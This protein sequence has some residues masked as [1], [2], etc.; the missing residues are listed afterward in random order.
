MK[1][2]RLIFNLLFKK[3]MQRHP[4]IIMEGS[5]Q[6]TYLRTD[7]LRQRDFAYGFRTFEELM[8]KIGRRPYPDRIT[9]YCDNV[10]PEFQKEFEK[11]SKQLK[12]KYGTPSTS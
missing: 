7:K 3:K 10:N 9:V 8:E 4:F 12:E 11:Q 6:I 2:L 5:I 1:K